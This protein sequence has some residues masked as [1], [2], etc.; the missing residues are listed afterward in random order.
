LAIERGHGNV[1][2]ISAHA[3]SGLTERGIDPAGRGRT[4]KQCLVADLSAARLIVA[5]EEAE[6][7]P[8]LLERF[9]DWEARVRYWHVRDIE[10][11]VPGKALAGLATRI[12]ELVVELISKD[13]ITPPLGPS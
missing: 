4:P 6:H 3:I 7:R 5:L 9:P 8:L 12:D 2:P 1:G 13:A 11:E 10:F